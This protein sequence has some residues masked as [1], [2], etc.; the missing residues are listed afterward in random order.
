[1]TAET[2]VVALENIED[3]QAFEAAIIADYDARTAVKREL[4]L[5]LASLLW[6][7]RRATAIETDL[8]QI[9]AEILSDGLHEYEITVAA[10]GP[11]RK[12]RT[13]RVSDPEEHRL[14]L[15]NLLR[16]SRYYIANRSRVNEPEFTMGRDEISSRFYEGAA[17]GTVMLGEPPRTPLFEAQFDWP[18]ALITFPFDSPEIARLLAEL[19]AD[20]ERLSRV[21]CNNVRNSALRHD[22]VHRIREVFEVLGLPPTAGMLAREERLRALAG[23][24]ADA[25]VGPRVGLLGERRQNAAHEHSPLR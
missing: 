10:S 20:P 18:D 3:Y 1:L 19:D 7:M 21:Q 25:G 15:A 12:Q 8:L 5:R 23:L 11:D 9:Q 4:V 22:W 16:R 14:L 24:A 13:F 6:R 2:V 17:A